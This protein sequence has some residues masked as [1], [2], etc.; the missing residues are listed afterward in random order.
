MNKKT[1]NGYCNSMALTFEKQRS[2]HWITRAIAFVIQ[3]PVTSEN[4]K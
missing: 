3:Y 1:I 4:Q 2:G